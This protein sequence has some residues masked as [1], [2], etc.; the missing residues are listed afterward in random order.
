[1]KIDT[2]DTLPCGHNEHWISRTDGCR[3]CEL[4]VN[5]GTTRKV[6]LAGRVSYCD[7]RGDPECT[8]RL[9]DRGGQRISWTDHSWSCEGVTIIR[10]GPFFVGYKQ[11][12][13]GYRP[14]QH[15]SGELDEIGQYHGTS[16]TPASQAF[17]FTECIKA[18]KRADVVYAWI[19]DLEAF[20]T[21]WELG[22]ATALGKRVVVA[23][24]P[25]QSD[26]CPPCN[27][28]SIT[29]GISLCR[30]FDDLWFA[31]HSAEV[32]RVADPIEGLRR[33]F[34]PALKTESPIE[35]MLLTAMG[36]I[37][38]GYKLHSQYEVGRYRLD[39]ALIGP[40]KIAIECDG[41]DFH[42]R[43]KE[44]AANDRS[45]DR[46][47]QLDGWMVLRFTGSE[48]YRSASACA[49]QIMQAIR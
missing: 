1:M 47:L 16:L 29:L 10:T 27:L 31:L 21:L 18:I 17:V 3:L 37:P 38:A 49:A 20:G 9:G 34:P 26:T 11:H 7:W 25:C 44:Q 6:Y 32:I 39:F 40:R 33:I 28:G 4:H 24:P 8:K 48:I 36:S 15:G 5:R 13:A 41:H 35:Q 46:A 45:R 14:H 43:T 30:R 19:E 23:L 42:E 12:G 22:Y 2:S